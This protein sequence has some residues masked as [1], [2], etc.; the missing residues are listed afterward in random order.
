MDQPD[1]G[2]VRPAQASAS[3]G[4]NRERGPQAMQPH[5]G[6]RRHNDGRKR[7]GSLNR[8]GLLL[9]PLAARGERQDAGENCQRLRKR[10]QRGGELEEVALQGLAC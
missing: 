1:P 9:S 2:S 10:Q 6:G 5:L 3:L 7:H 8:G 4:Q